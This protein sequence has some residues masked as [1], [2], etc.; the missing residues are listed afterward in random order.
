MAAAAESGVV[1][2]VRIDVTRMHETWMELLFPRQRGAANSVLGKWQPKTAREKITYNGWYWLGVP[3]VAIVYPLVLAGYFVRFQA[4]RLD[5]TAMRLG[6][7][8][9]SLFFLV[10]WGGLTALARYRFSMAGFLAVGAAS[11]VAVLAALLALGF[12]RIGGR[13]TT[14]VFAYPFA[15]TAL[16][17]PPVVASLYSPTVADAVL[18]RSQSVAIWLLDNVLTYAELD[19]YLRRTYD[20]RGLAYAGM[21]F[22][23]AIPVGWLLGIL[24]TIA[25]LVRPRP[26]SSDED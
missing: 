15:M 17:L 14:V 8:G 12:R 22:G 10:V 18:P 5:A 26:A 19:V 20:L 6:T 21:W 11:A 13:G 16:F 4:A 25:D 1:D 2:G 3:V 24:V 23:I 7:L 9:V